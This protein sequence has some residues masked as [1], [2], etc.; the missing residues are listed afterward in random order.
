MIP[1]EFEANVGKDS[2]YCHD[3]ES[4]EHL[5][6]GQH[7]RFVYHILSSAF[8][9]EFKHFV[10]FDLSVTAGD[11]PLELLIVELPLDIADHSHMR[12]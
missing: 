1:Q 4:E 9:H 10:G 12:L 6:H 3:D 2:Q 8:V 11:G 7:C 5:A